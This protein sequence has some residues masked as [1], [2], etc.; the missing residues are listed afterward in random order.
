MR[1][2]SVLQLIGFAV[3]AAAITTAVAVL[4]PWLPVAASRESGRIHFVYWFTTAIAI[5][6]FAVVASALTYSIIHFRARPDDDSD[7]PPTHG[8]TTIEIVWT[9]IPA[10]LVTAISIVSAVVLAQ[11]SNAGSNPLVVK[12]KA[13]QFAWAFT[14]P[15]G[16][17][18]G[19]LTLP[20]GRHVKLDITSQDVIHSFWVPQFSQKQDAVPGQHNTIVVTPDRLGTY[21]VICTE[22]CGLG[23][24]LMR[25]SVKV[26]SPADF[27]SF[28]KNGGQQSGPPGLA[29]FQQ[30]GCGG[31]HTLKPAGA[32]GTTGPDLDNLASDARKAN[33]GSLAKYVHE[34]IVDP[35]AYIVPGYQDAMPHIFGTQIPQNQLQQLVQYL[36]QG[37][38]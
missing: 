1:R 21:P 8:H 36:S 16:K 38:K 2:G 9:A 5:G 30:N 32:T 23:H 14:Y 18:Y 27:A 20:K 29:V 12:V 6:V 4:I 35:A 11:N 19:T 13:Q 22:L 26:V 31:C 33:R 17:S 7:G 3:V 24:A 28:M 34:S 37:G 10:V 15:N 25:S